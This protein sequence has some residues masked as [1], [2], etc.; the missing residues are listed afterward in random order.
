MEMANF[1]LEEKQLVHKLF[2][3][4]APRF[5]DFETSYTSL[6][7]APFTF[8]DEYISRLKLSVLELKGIGLYFFP[9]AVVFDKILYSL[10]VLILIFCL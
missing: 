9:C 7:K 8:T 3:V 1:W 4:L 10:I 2:K 5:T 6:F